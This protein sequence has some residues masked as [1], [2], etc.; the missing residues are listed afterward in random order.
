[1]TLRAAS[2]AFTDIAAVRAAENCA[3]VTDTTPDDTTVQSYIDQASDVIAIA[4]DMRIAG[5]QTVKARP[6]RIEDT[7]VP[8]SCCG[9]DAIPLGDARPSVTEVKIDGDVLAADYYWLHWNGI[10]W[11]L[12]RKPLATQLSPQR[13]PSDRKR[14][15][16]D[17]EDGT[18]SITIEQ[19]IHV[20]D[21]L[22]Q[23]AVMEIICDFAAEDAKRPNRIE[24]ARSMS[25][26]GLTVALDED[27]IDRIRSG[28]MGPMTRRM[29]GVLVPD[30]RATSAVWAPELMDGWTLNLELV[31]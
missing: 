30:G 13:W 4:T 26:G 29:M 15:A 8:C 9:L 25:G 6:C 3:C 17:S 5:R 10:S 23:S 31:P 24:G 7:C 28:D 19:G 14:W 1:M 20:D 22:I 27:R 18:F 21:F 11:V 12:A 2:E 16:A